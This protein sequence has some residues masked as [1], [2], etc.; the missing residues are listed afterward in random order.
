MKTLSRAPLPELVAV[1]DGL[2]LAVRVN[3]RARRISLKVDATLDR[4]VLV[5]PSPRAL[6][7]GV[8]F[9][10][11]RALWLKG[12]L[13][14]VPPRMPF[15]DGVVLPYRGE[16][17][18]IRHVLDGRGGAWLVEREIHV[19]GRAEHLPRRLGDWLKT[20]ARRLLS[21]GV[22]AAAARIERRPGRLSVRDP[23]S[24]WGSCAPDGRLSFS[25]RLVLAPPSVLDYVVAH[26]V[27]HL[28]EANHGPAFW[29]L[30][31]RLDPEFAAAKRWLKQHGARLHRYG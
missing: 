20:E 14:K 25:W 11:S 27:A 23:K 10:E 22:A 9:A 12:A 6:A 7:E 13:A 21:S 19:A 31:E 1:E 30:V 28:V 8:K 15:A 16:P 5:L 3:R 24:R 29:A 17:H 4:P 26:E 18:R 2:E